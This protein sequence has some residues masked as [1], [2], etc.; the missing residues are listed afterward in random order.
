[1]PV[2]PLPP[3]NTGRL[4]V[5]YTDGQHQHTFVVRFAANS[6]PAAASARALAF[7][8][9]LLPVLPDE[10]QV[11]ALRQSAAG[12]DVTFPFSDPALEG[13][14][15]TSVSALSP[16]N[17]PRQVNWQGRGSA[18][19]RRVRVGLYGLIISTPENYRLE[20]AS[21]TAAF[22]NAYQALRGSL[23]TFVTIAGDDPV[24]YPYANV[25]FN[26]YWETEQ[27]G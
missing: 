1:M 19:G 3:S 9:P 6:T 10:W 16:V 8:T 24:W 11:L 5:D 27:R 20:Q 26:S 2:S 15:G 18:S 22:E 17:G 12:S 25:N 13:L 7:L 23:N 21:W 4:Y 14:A